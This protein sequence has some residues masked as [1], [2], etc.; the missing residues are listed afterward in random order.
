MPGMANLD[1]GTE[2]RRLSEL[3]G[4]MS[5]EELLRLAREQSELTDVAREALRNEMA[6]RKLKVRPEPRPKPAPMPETPL[7]SP[8]YK[9]RKLVEIA[10]AWSLADA[11][12]LQQLLDQ[13]GIPFFMGAE[14]ATGVDEVTSN[15]G[16]GV[17]V[18]IMNIGLPWA[19]QALEYYEPV[20]E[21]PQEG[22]QHLEEV[23]MRCPK[24]RSEEIVFEELSGEPTATEKDS[25]EQFE[26]K[27]DACGYRWKDD[28]IL[29]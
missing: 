24:C 11:L 6:Q 18:K 25:P 14:N 21:P 13:A 12:Q 22:E 3:Y 23:A 27:C 17:S 28:G 7:D 8:Y 2:W 29:K 9:D 20:N 10:T 1:P 4:R 15:F 19:R 5:D 26:W 16:N